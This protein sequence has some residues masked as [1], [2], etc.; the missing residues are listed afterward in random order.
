MSDL[1]RCGQRRLSSDVRE[2]IVSEFISLDGVVE[3]PGDEPTHPHAGWTMKFGSPELYEF[4]LHETLEA[5]SLLLGRHTY[6]GFLAAWPSRDGPFADKMNAMAKDVATSSHV[7]P[8]WNASALDTPLRDS[9]ARLKAG[10]GGPILVAG[11]ATLVKF[12]LSERLVDE[13]RLMTYPVI[14]GGGLGIF[15]DAHQRVDFD[16]VGTITFERGV[17]LRTL[18]LKN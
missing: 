13:L 2:L 7:D 4:K 10:P 18:R 15:P 14:L 12:L 11:S 8:A 17:E 16:L 3:A 9:I 5:Q 1:R 6:E